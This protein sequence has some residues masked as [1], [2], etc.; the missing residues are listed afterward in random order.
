MPVQNLS[1]EKRRGGRWFLV[2]PNDA[3]GFINRRGHERSWSHPRGAANFLKRACD[4]VPGAS[5]S[6]KMPSGKVR[7]F[8]KAVLEGHGDHDWDK[9]NLVSRQD[10][11]SQFDLWRCKACGEEYKRRSLGW[12]PDSSQC[13]LNPP[14]E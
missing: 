6:L 3:E 12:H 2:D 8:G 4:R 14:T 9:V 5:F 10:K 11:I 1:M 13:P 7:L